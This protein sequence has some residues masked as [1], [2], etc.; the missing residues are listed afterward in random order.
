MAAILEFLHVL[1]VALMGLIVRAAAGDQGTI[2]TPGTLPDLAYTLT[3]TEGEVPSLAVSL[4]FNGDA[5]GST[6]I[7]LAEEWGGVTDHPADIAAL[8][9]TTESGE[10]VSV[11]SDTP[12]AWTLVHP[13]NARLRCAY[14][15]APAARVP[16]QTN[17]Y[18]TVVSPSLV[19]VIGNL[20]LLYPDHLRTPEP[21]TIVLD[22]SGL[23]RSSWNI[24]SVAGIGPGPHTVR[25]PGERFLHSLIIAGD[26]RLLER[27]VGSN[28]IGVYI[29]SRDFNFADDDFA[30]LCQTI[31][32][33][34]RDFF[35]DHSDPWFLVS[36]MP[37][38][39]ARPN[40]YSI[41]GTGLTN[42]FSLYCSPGL[43]LER[44]TGHLERFERLLAHEYMHTW[45]GGKI[46]VRETPGP[47]GYWFTEGFT[48]FF[49]RRVL[50]ESGLWTDA[51][52]A[53]D[54]SE[55]L[56][57]Y[58]A[59]P[60]R[61]APNARI[62][63]A[64]WANRNVGDL[65]YRRGDLIALAIDERMRE[66]SDGERGVDTLLRDLL[67]RVVENGETLDNARIFEVIETHTDPAFAAGLRAVVEEGADPPV[68][69]RTT[70]PSLRLSTRTMQSTDPGFDVEAT[71][72]TRIIT[73]VVE[74]SGAHRAG[75]RDGM[76]LASFSM[77][78][79]A[80]GPPQAVIAVREGGGAER[81]ITYEAVSPPKPVRAYV[82]DNAGG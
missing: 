41:G 3:Y 82:L 34:E 74:N 16:K 62:S 26:G 57:R 54:L 15:I 31:I 35:A 39:E 36:I 25:M 22:L 27:R 71:R 28:R 20:G 8:D 59:N 79:G 24:A 10:A 77:D 38:G 21:R 72:T 37:Q 9:V 40:G 75:V 60:E 81:T 80:G 45:I 48:D 19:H 51:Q 63:E 17:D 1:L 12:G 52:Y 43:S 5:D 69:E 78:A 18:R 44:S 32:Q 56:S 46:S 11:V 50:H 49:T 4:S 42:A 7:S 76:A 30:D 6:T 55:A 53:A 33:T 14:T 65:P 67:T 13:P 58:D 73:G 23:D 2:Q 29:H 64:F 66:A 68:P 70:R 61:N 47:L